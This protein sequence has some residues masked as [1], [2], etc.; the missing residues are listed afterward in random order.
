VLKDRHQHIVGPVASDPRA[1]PLDP[2]V[3]KP[4][5]LVAADR[6]AIEGQYSQ[7]DTMQPQRLE[8]MPQQ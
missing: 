7:V 8:G 3:D 6:A 2:F 4:A 1:L 5:L